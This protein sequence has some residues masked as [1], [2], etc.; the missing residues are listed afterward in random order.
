MDFMVVR[1]INFDWA[2]INAHKV[3]VLIKS[4]VK[5]SLLNSLIGR[6]GDAARSG[7]ERDLFEERGR[8]KKDSLCLEGSFPLFITDNY[9]FCFA[10]SSLQKQLTLRLESA[11]NTRARPSTKHQ[12]NNRQALKLTTLGGEASPPNSS[13]DC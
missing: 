10:R 6:K 9:S 5:W 2:L 8:Q 7:G 11:T 13:V 3:N 4:T 1:W 12:P